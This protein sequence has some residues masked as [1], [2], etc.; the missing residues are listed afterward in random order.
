MNA[1]TRLGMVSDSP[2]DAQTIRNAEG[3]EAGKDYF[4][5]RDGV[6]FAG[7]HLLVDLWK[8]QGLDDPQA[9]DAALRAG[10]EA[11]GATILH[12]H[13]HHFSPNG[14]VSGVLVLA[15]SHIS[16]HTW[17]ERGFAAIDIF[18]CGACDPYRALPALKEAFRAEWV[19]LVEQRRGVIR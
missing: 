16:I 13:F 17:P 4:I 7:M 11:S 8:A 3:S 15:E 5:E 18:M 6:R 1:L 9:I 12:G 10:A 19:E 2:S 14:G